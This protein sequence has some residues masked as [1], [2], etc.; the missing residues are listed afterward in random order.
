MLASGRYLFGS[1][2]LDAGEGVLRRDGLPLHLAPKSLE[3]L[4][5]L[6]ERHG[7]LVDKSRI[8]EQVWPGVT[9]E[10]CNL[11]QHVASLRRALGDDARQPS[12]I[13]TVSRRGYRFVADVVRR[14]ASDPRAT[15]LAP[16]EAPAPPPAPSAPG[17][18]AAGVLRSA[19]PRWRLVRVAGF[20]LALAA[21][22]ASGAWA[23]FRP[24]EVTRRLALL[25]VANLTGDPHN[26][27]LATLLG[28]ALQQ[29]LSSVRGLEVELLKPATFEHV[30]GIAPPGKRHAGQVDAI[31]ETAVLTAGARV[32]VAV[33]LIEAR[34]DTLIWADILEADHGG[35]QGLEARME[36]VVLS[37]LQL[38]RADTF[39]PSTGRAAASRELAL[40]NYYWGRRTP[41]VAEEYLEHFTTA[42]ELDP[43]FAAAH[44]GL[45]LGYLQ[46]AEQRAYE[47]QAA[48]RL[49]EASAHRALQLKPALAEAHLAVGGVAEARSDLAGALDQYQ[50][51]LL[52]D[53]SLARAH[54]RASRL[55]SV[56]GR[57]PEGIIEA[58]RALELEPGGLGPGM[59][60]ASALL[61]A[62]RLEE[63]VGQASATVRAHPRA[64]EAHELM[65]RTHQ[66]AGRSPEATAAF[67]EAIR[68]SGGSP[69]YL[70]RLARVRA[71]EG[72]LQEA[73]RLLQELERTEPAW[74]ISALDL[75]PVLAALGEPDRAV[76]LL[77]QEAE[78][79]GAWLVVQLAGLRIPELDCEGRL[80]RLLARVRSKAEQVGREVLLAEARGLPIAG[81]AGAAPELL[82]A[83]PRSAS[84][85]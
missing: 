59:A 35:L 1:F 55:L 63:A 57:H 31:V 74:R 7:E 20:G 37:R 78:A 46:A 23:T 6:V 8:F 22:T 24:R 67:G 26:V 13:E 27:T 10:D 40:A 65:G 84:P 73:R 2:E 61:M 52:L 25:P 60:L 77:D 15:P 38:N 12:F 70:S 33:E 45:A 29:N 30:A 64:A 32:Q 54:V 50:Q 76:H 66:A 56:L 11:A 41:H 83:R 36:E 68:L 28:E 39:R 5:A 21:V 17:T 85:P 69:V 62:G 71:M 16:A 48:L 44:A 18:P 80:Q 3:V 34:T 51:A 82:S 79:G 4:L 49:A 43:S 81:A 53:G 9:V 47:P 75:A 72:Q 42:V 14:A 19:R 58:R